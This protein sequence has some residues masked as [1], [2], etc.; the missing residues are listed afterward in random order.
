MGCDGRQYELR[1]TYC[2]E[3][4]LPVATGGVAGVALGEVHPAVVHD[5]ERAIILIAACNIRRT[6][7]GHGPVAIG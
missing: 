4:R 5:G 1:A 3:Q 2:L 7:P 6:Y